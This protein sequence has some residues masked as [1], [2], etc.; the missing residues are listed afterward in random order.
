MIANGC[1]QKTILVSFREPIQQKKIGEDIPVIDCITWTYF[2]TR[3]IQLMEIDD[4]TTNR[5]VDKIS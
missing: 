1:S 4:R 5:S 2:E 3:G